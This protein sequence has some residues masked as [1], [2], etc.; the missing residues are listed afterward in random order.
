MIG[1]VQRVSRASVTVEGE[2]VG[3]IGD[4]LLALWCAEPAD[5]EAVAG[6]FVDKVLKLRIFAD[7]AGRMNRSVVEVG[8]GLLVER[9]V[10]SGGNVRLLA[11]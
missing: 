8:G 3:A 1:L 6:R 7:D 10:I 4:G 11:T 5:T 9:L 2:I